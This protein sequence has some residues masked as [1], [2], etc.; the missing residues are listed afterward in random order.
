MC[1][2]YIQSATTTGLIYLLSQLMNISFHKIGIIP[3]NRIS[4]SAGVHRWINLILII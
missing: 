4:A 3:V 2:F 1:K